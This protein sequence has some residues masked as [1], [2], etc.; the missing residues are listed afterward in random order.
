[1]QTGHDKL[2]AMFV[3][4]VIDDKDKGTLTSVALAKP[5]AGYLKCMQKTTKLERRKEIGR[6]ANNNNAKRPSGSVHAVFRNM[7]VH[8]DALMGA[9]VDGLLPKDPLKDIAAKQQ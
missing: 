2:M 3:A 6:M 7:P 1:M 8:D 5:T 4:G 9:F